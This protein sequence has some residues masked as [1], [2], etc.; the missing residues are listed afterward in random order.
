MKATLAVIAGL[1]GQ[2]YSTGVLL[3]LY[4]YPSSVWNDG[5]A[6]WN[7]VFDAI[8]TY[9]NVPWLVVVNPDSGPGASPEPANADINYISGVSQLN[10]FA[11]VETIGYVR[12]EWS[13][14]SLD[15]LRANVTVYS[16]WASYLDADLSIK[17]IFFDETSE[18]YEYLSEAT[19]IARDAFD[20]PITLICNFGVSTS[21]QFYEICDVVVAFESGLNVPGA[22][23]YQSQTTITNNIPAGLQSQASVIVHSFTGNA[24][25]GNAATTAL[26]NNYLDTLQ[27]NGVGWAYFTSAGY[28]SVTTPPATVGANAQGVAP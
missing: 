1:I 15:E 14:S 26:L 27:A 8:S 7:P 25:D 17:G 5:A 9:P 28:E 23:Q 13:T 6:N 10:A 2:A 3:P 16:N 20:E 22:P 12:T 4:V 19:A 18:D 11:N 24:Y 21:A